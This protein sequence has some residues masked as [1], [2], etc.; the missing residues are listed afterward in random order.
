[1]TLTD[2]LQRSGTTLA[3]LADQL[4]C[5]RGMLSR[6]ARGRQIPRPDLMRRIYDAT[7]GAVTAN[8]FYGLDGQGHRPRREPAKRCA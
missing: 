7:Q 3:Q 4:G 6:I 1:M 2:Y 5:N 8:D